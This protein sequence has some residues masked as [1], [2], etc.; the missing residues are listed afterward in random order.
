MGGKKVKMRRSALQKMRCIGARE[1]ECRS[2]GFWFVRTG[3]F[4]LPRL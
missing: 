1:K 3:D 2:C 4:A